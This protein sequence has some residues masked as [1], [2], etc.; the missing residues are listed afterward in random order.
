MPR[1]HSRDVVT[2]QAAREISLR[3]MRW[4][5]DT[6]QDDYGILFALAAYQV[7][8]VRRMHRVPRGFHGEMDGLD[9]ILDAA[10][11]EFGLT[12]LEMVGIVAEEFLGATRPMLRTER[13]PG[14]RR[15]AGF[16]PDDEEADS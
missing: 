5:K 4:W 6:D 7:N 3:I 11:D 9:N 12:D 2:T 1:R 8:G 10:R 13:H 15:E 14:E 16:A